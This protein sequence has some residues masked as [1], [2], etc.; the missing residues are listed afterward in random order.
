MIYPN[1]SKGN[2]A[3]DTPENGTL[4]IFSI[5]GMFISSFDLNAG[6]NTIKLDLPAGIYV[7]KTETKDKNFSNK[8]VIQ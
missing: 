8:L 5:N 3:I 7:T 2:I 4:K 6:T 1:P